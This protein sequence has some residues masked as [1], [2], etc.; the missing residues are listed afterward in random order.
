MFLVLQC[1]NGVVLCLMVVSM[2]CSM[3]RNVAIV[4]AIDNCKSGILVLLCD[5]L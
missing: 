5:L 2:T 3:L 4:V 1:S